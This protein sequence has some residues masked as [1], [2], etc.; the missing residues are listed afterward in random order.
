MHLSEHKPREIGAGAPEGAI[1][2]ALDMVRAG[3]GALCQYGFEFESHEEAVSRIYRA[4]RGAS[5]VDR[6]GIGERREH[7]SNGQKHA[8]VKLA[9]AE[10]TIPR[11][12]LFRR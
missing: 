10:I 12:E 3:V 7:M 2:I 9:C 1:E 4:M 6:S 5:N 11:S 8:T